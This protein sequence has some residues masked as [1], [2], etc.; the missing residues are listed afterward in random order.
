MK[1]LKI[2][3]NAPQFFIIFFLFAILFAIE[4]VVTISVLP[5]NLLLEG[6]EWAIK[7]MLNFINTERDGTE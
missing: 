4:I 6:I 5:F 3:F 1:I 2:L 7:K